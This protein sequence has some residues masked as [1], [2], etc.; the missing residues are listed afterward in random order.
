MLCARAR[1]VGVVASR[2]AL[3][4]AARVCLF[5]RSTSVWIWSVGF[6][7][8]RGAG[9]A[10]R[11]ARACVRT[12]FVGVRH[13]W[14]LWGGEI[15]IWREGRTYVAMRPLG[16]EAQ[17]IGGV[18]D[19]RSMCG[20]YDY[21]MRRRTCARETTCLAKDSSNWYWNAVFF[22]FLRLLGRETGVCI[23]SV[24]WLP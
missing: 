10:P 21:L 12:G 14:D 3:Q 16:G 9:R 2:V 19:L 20:D 4:L 13:L 18:P 5:Y 17:V 23:V 22:F 15:L 7:T 6:T 1:G 8:L 11:R 24:E